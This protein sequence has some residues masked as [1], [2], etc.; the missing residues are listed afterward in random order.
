MT[1]PP[2]ITFKDWGSPP[3]AQGFQGGDLYGVA[4]KLDYLQDLGVTALYL[5]PIFASASNHRYHTFDYFQVDPLLGGNA[6]L[7]T[8]LDEAHARG[9]RIV[10]DGVFNHASRG[11]WAFHHILETGS[12]SPYLDW[13]YINKFPLRPYNSSK[14]RPANYGAWWNN[15]ALPKINVRN[16]GARAYLL[17]CA[18][19]WVEFG[20]D[21]WRLDVAEE[22][23]DDDFWREFRQTVKQA[24][25]EAYIVA[26]I[27]HPAQHWLQG[28]MFDAVMN[29][30]FT[31]ATLSYA[32]SHDTRPDRFEHP[33][34]PLK[35][36]TAADFRAAIDTM[37]ALYD[38]QI[39]YAQ[40]NLLDSHD[41]PR[42][43]WLMN[44]A[45]GTLELAVLIQMT[46]PGAP[47]IYYGDE[48]G[49][50]SAGDPYCRAAFPWHTPETWNN[51]LLATYR[52][53]T[54]MRH[55]HPVLRTGDFKFVA[56]EGSAVAYTRHLNG[57]T[58]LIAL[59][60]L[61]Q[62][63]TLNLPAEHAAYTSIYPHMGKTIYA[64]NGQ[65]SLQIPAR[66]GMVL[67]AQHAQP[68]S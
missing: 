60:N 67:R 46:F 32:G 62:P 2:G 9:I 7:R 31:A 21:G 28:D 54:A 38:W 43:A 35:K 27:W 24:N 5:N 18:R 15:P 37:H 20:I 14:T 68:I 44:D 8:L 40:L 42:A 41:M 33:D 45:P 19:Y 30:V 39:N 29:Y 4:D 3:E 12:N 25:P 53:L 56:A 49:L 59:N 23:D 58:A 47:C 66:S 52:Q 51:N 48:I 34:V 50:S 1:H 57:Q 26:E 22:I 11:F 6:A 13:F 63:V 55:A 16:P 36:Y 65:I 61:T 17:E 10:L 64:H